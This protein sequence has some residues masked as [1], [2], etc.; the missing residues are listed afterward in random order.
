MTWQEKTCVPDARLSA[1]HLEELIA[2]TCRSWRV[3]KETSPKAPGRKGN[4]KDKPINFNQFPFIFHK[5]RAENASKM[6]ENEV[7][8]VHPSSS[9]RFSR[10]PRRVPTSRLG[11]L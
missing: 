6:N 5:N 8:S 11:R 2:K 7:F 1:H 4:T 10:S 9:R 3:G